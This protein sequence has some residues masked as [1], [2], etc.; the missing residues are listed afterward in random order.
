MT[1]FASAGKPPEPSEWMRDQRVQRIPAGIRDLTA[2]TL[3]ALGVDPSTLKARQWTATFGVGDILRALRL[4]LKEPNAS[5]QILNEVEA[6]VI[7]ILGDN[8]RVKL[9]LHNHTVA[10]IHLTEKES[11]H[12]PSSQ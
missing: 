1:K 2:C 6:R 12:E 4:N 11:R 3:S 7:R 5:R 8:Y 9:S 10:H